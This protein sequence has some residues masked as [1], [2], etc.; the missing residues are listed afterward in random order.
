[1]TLAFPGAKHASKRHV[2]T[3][4]AFQPPES[5]PL[6]DQT[7]PACVPH[8]DRGTRTACASMA[9][10]AAVRGAAPPRRGRQKRR[11]HEDRS[12]NLLLGAGKRRREVRFLDEAEANR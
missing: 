4:S 2:T 1:M 6:E 10:D 9:S 8:C 11:R 5:D 3:Q 7:D 12:G